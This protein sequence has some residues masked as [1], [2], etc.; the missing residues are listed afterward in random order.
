MNGGLALSK[1]VRG[2]FVPD[3][4][5]V[6]NPMEVVSG[7]DNPERVTS[8]FGNPVEDNSPDA[9]TFGFCLSS[10]HNKPHC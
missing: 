9:Q 7:L 5:G 2:G 3:N 1:P 4:P 10:Q 6:Y 8:S